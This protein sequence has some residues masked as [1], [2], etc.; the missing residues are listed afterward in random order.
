[1]QIKSLT[2]DEHTN[3]SVFSPKKSDH[4]I[5]LYCTEGKV[6]LKIN[7]NKYIINPNDFYIVPPS[8]NLI[9]T[10]SENC[11][12]AILEF[13]YD[14]VLGNINEGHFFDDD[15][16][17]LRFMEKLYFLQTTYSKFK[18]QLLISYQNILIIQI[19]SKTNVVNEV[20]NNDFIKQ[21][22]EIIS[23]INE[24][25]NKNI[26]I[27]EL[28]RNYSYSYTHLRR[29][30]KKQTGYSPLKYLNEK[31][32][33]ESKKLLRDT[34]LPINVISEKIGF[35]GSSFFTSFFHKETGMTPK[36]YRLQG[37]VIDNDTE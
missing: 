22:N 30:F 18:S 28:F 24:N 31:R 15:K 7:K 11:K 13:K 23:Y 10:T 21:I 5:L 16:T 17:V 29:V 36:E 35:T 27:Q 9:I 8:T 20:N 33:S 25:Y 34:N 6:T 26:N 12:T 19:L 37:K 4:F 3:I 2:Y 1:M 14:H 32:L